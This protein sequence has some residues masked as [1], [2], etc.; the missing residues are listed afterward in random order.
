MKTNKFFHHTIMPSFPDKT[1]K[2]Y[3]QEKKLEETRNADTAIRRALSNEG[4]R[5]VRFPRNFTFVTM[6]RIRTEQERKQ[7]RNHTIECVSAAA[8]ILC[9]VGRL[10]FV[11]DFSVFSLPDFSFLS[12]AVIAYNSLPANP[13]IVRGIAFCFLFFI[14]LDKLLAKYFYDKN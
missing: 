12:D 5:Q 9:A 4:S 11:L 6:E 14:V 3:L 8:V 1:K 13:L 7:K 10:L 2:S